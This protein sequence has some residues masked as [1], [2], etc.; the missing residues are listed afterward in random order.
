MLEQGRWLHFELVY[1]NIGFKLSAMVASCVHMW[2]HRCWNKG[3]GCIFNWYMGTSGLNY[4]LWL[5]VRVEFVNMQVELS[6]MVAV[7]RSLLQPW[8]GF[9]SS[10]SL[11]FH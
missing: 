6:A 8:L 2:E 3:D 5:H 7:F 10:C 11:I 1:G 4:Q 9:R